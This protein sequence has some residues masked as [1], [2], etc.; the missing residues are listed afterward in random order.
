M[1]FG[2]CRSSIRD[3]CNLCAMQLGMIG[4]GRMG[5][6]MARRVMRHGHDVVAYDRDAAAVGGAARDGMGP[7][8]SPAE[9]AGLLTA[10]R[11]VWLMVP[12][13]VVDAAIA[14]IQ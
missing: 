7:A 11:A 13:Q 5:A 8:T 12:D 2:S 4:L 10:P 1:S 14:T 9:L 6:N 3:K